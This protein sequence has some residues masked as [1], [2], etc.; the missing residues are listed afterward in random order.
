MKTLSKIWHLSFHHH[1][2]EIELKNVFI[3]LLIA[4]AVYGYLWA[5]LAIC[6]AFQ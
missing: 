6:E 5:A 4:P 3:G 2:T 1:G